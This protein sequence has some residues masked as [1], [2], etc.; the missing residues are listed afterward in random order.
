LDLPS[1]SEGLGRRDAILL[2]A[3]PP[4]FRLALLNSFKL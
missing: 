1:V 3:C 2:P 4:N